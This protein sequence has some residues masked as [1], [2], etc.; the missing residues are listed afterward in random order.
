MKIHRSAAAFALAA[1]MLGTLGAGCS[2]AADSGTDQQKQVVE[3]VMRGM[4]AGDTVV[5]EEP[6]AVVEGKLKTG[7]VTRRVNLQTFT[8]GK[9]SDATWEL[10]DASGAK[11]ASGG[12]N[13]ATL[14]TAHPFYLPGVFDSKTRPIGD[15]SLLWL[16]QQEYRELKATSGTTINLRLAEIPEWAPRV[17]AST[18]A[19]KAFTSL[20]SLI[21]TANKENKDLTYARR[22]DGSTEEMILVNGKETKVPVIHLRNWFGAYTILDREDNPLVLSFTLDPKVEKKQLDVMTGD[23]AELSKLMNY[24]VKEIVYTGR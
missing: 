12:W 15:A 13:Q 6:N 10:N 14:N 16:A 4:I 17:K 23:G 11:V 20:I 19:N 24:K 2:R 3:S 7:P 22:E 8:M 21:T 18:G 1:A 5:L 9:T